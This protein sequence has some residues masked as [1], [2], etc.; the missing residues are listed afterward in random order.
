MGPPRHVDPSAFVTVK[1]G[2]FAKG[3]PAASTP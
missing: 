1:A 2:D 3:K